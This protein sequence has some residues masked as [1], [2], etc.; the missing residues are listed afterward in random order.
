HLAQ[1]S[2]GFWPT[3]DPYSFPGTTTDTTPLANAA[4]QSSLTPNSW[5]GGATLTTNGVAGLDLAPVNDPLSGKKSWFMFDD[6]V[7]C[8]GAGITDTG[9][10]DI[11]TTPLNRKL[12]TSNTNTFVVNGTTMPSTL[13]WQ[14]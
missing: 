2:S 10:A 13:G 12:A 11:Q 9:S 1:F 14:T 8:L 3:V 4:G 6:E 5:V 7:V